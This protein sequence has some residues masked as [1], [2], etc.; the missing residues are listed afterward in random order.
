MYLYILVSNSLL[1]DSYFSLWYFRG[2]WSR[3]GCRALLDTFSSKLWQHGIQCICC[4]CGYSGI[5]NFARSWLSWRELI[6]SKRGR[7]AF[8]VQS[9]S[10]GHIY[11]S[12]FTG[13]SPVFVMKK[14]FL[15]CINNFQENLNLVRNGAKRMIMYLYNLVS[16]SLLDGS[17]FH[18]DI[19]TRYGLVWIVELCWIFLYKVMTT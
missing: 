9:I 7:V 3:V 19:F 16:N 8:T 12:I 18:Y 11:K 6:S 2:V 5:R 1:G 13:Y 10:W 15:L 4:S 17:Y 14:K